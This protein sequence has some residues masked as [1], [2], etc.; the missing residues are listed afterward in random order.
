MVLTWKGRADI[1]LSGAT[2]YL[3]SE[4][5]G[6]ATG[7]RLDGRRVYRFTGDAALSD[8]VVHA[9]DESQPITDIKV[10]L[11]DPADPENASLEGELWH[12]TFLERLRDENWGVIRAT[13]MTHTDA[14][15][16]IRWSDRRRP[17]HVFANG[18]LNT[19]NPAPGAVDTNGQAFAGDRL[20]GVPYEHLVALAN[21]TDLD[22]WISVP[23]LADD[24]YVAGL[25]R[26][27]RYGSDGKNPY[28]RAKANPVWAPL[29]PGRRVFIEY[30]NAIWS[31]GDSTPQG[32]W[33]A[34]QAENWD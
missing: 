29:E 3:A 27:L 26:L 23:H 20:T 9:I 28:N 2:A 21:A 10:W 5:D 12:P 32:D 22:L 25:A 4:S 11:A 14:S 19:R 16:Q 30:S 1:R 8:L 18:I 34:A 6:A 15:P 7:S 33:A 13:T 24:G 17:D 31:E